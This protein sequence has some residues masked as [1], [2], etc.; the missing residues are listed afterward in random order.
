MPKTPTDAEQDA[1]VAE[2]APEPPEG[3][4]EAD[5]EVEMAGEGDV[6]EVT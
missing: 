4:T 2:V 6:G 3:E 1:D 5:Y